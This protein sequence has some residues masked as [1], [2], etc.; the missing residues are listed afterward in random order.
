M[1]LYLKSQKIYFER[2][3]EDLSLLIICK[4]DSLEGKANVFLIC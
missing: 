3:L 4:F 1:L 2:L